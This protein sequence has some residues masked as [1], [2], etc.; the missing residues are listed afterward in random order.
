MDAFQKVAFEDEIFE[1]K[2]FGFC[3]VLEQYSA[4]TLQLGSLLMCTSVCGRVS[5]LLP[6]EAA[7]AL[8]TE[9]PSLQWRL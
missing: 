1:F 5:L 4:P 3:N 7:F 9:G 6:F 8:L 2:A